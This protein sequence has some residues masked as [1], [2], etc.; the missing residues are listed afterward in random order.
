MHVQSGTRTDQ[1]VISR[2][3]SRLEGGQ[4]VDIVLASDAH[5]AFVWG[6]LDRLLDEPNFTFEAITAAGFGAVEAAVL[7]Y[8]LSLGGRR[9]A[10]TALANF[11]R[12]VSHASMFAIDR[13]SLLRSIL[14][15]SIDIEQIRDERCPVKL[16]ILAVNARTDGVTIFSG[17]QLSIKAVVAAATV[18]FLSPPVEIDGDSYWGDSELSQLPPAWSPKT[19]HRLIVAG[20]PSLFT[21]LCPDR[22]FSSTH[23]ATKCA[24]VHTI[25][26]S[27][28][29]VGAALFVRPWIDWGELTDMRDR[30]RQCAAG[31]LA[32]D[33]FSTDERPAIGCRAQY[34]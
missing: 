7:A 13:A 10:R 4:S 2:T 34:I 30:G 32:A 3:N 33:L 1:A 21:T 25:F 29:R 11:W 20:R 9:G 6:V 8:G 12:R 17:E 23:C 28:Y 31:W 24:P 18:P 15:Q 16:G 22:S 27:Q 26:D 14:E 5:G 19:S